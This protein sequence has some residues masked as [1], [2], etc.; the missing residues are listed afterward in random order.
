MSFAFLK[1]LS[2]NIELDTPKAWIVTLVGVSAFSIIQLWPALKMD[3][4]LTSSLALFISLWGF[5]NLVVRLTRNIAAKRDLHAATLARDQK[6]KHAYEARLASL[7]AT[8]ETVD[9]IELDQL[10]WILRQGKIRFSHSIKKGLLDKKVVEYARDVD[11][12]LFDVT[13]MVWAMRDELLKKHSR[14]G[15]QGAFPYSRH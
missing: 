11:A 9:G 8:L 10:I 1:D 2:E 3:G 13:P 6:E 4:V 7:L 14:K 12:A 15:Q 5:W